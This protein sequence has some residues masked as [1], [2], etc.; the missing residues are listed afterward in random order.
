MNY[1]QVRCTWGF[2]EEN[3]NVLQVESGVGTRRPP[4]SPLLPAGRERCWHQT[5]PSLPPPPCR[6]SPWVSRLKAKAAQQTLALTRR[7]AGPPA[8]PLD[9]YTALGVLKGALAA[10]PGPA[11]VVVSEGANTMVRSGRGGRR[12]RRV[13]V[14][15]GLE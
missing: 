5:P 3:R 2:V 13:S 6:Y 9:Y 1:R 4:P 11:P 8:H 14:P 7:L 10:M 15:G 12:V